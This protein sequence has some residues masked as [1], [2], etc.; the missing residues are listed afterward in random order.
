MAGARLRATRSISSMREVE[1]RPH[2]Q[3]HTVPLVATFRR[4]RSLD[5]AHALEGVE[6][7]PLELRQGDDPSLVVAH[8]CQVADLAQREQALVLGV[9]V[10]DGAGEVD[11]LGRRQAL[12]GEVGQAPQVQ[13][14][15][16]E[17]VQAVDRVVLDQARRRDRVRTSGAAPS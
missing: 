14:L 12:D 16:H 8:G 17:R 5:P 11:V 3:Q 15:D 10:G 2:V 1:R 6:Q 4:K 13:P 9:R 7:H